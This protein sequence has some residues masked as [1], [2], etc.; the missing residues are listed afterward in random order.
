MVRDVR[1]VRALCYILLHFLVLQCHSDARLGDA[2]GDIGWFPCQYVERRGAVADR[3]SVRI[4]IGGGGGGVSPAAAADPVGDNIPAAA[5]PDSERELPLHAQLSQMSMPSAAAASAAQNGDDIEAEVAELLA[6]MRKSS[7]PVTGLNLSPP[8]TDSSRVSIVSSRPSSDSRGS[9]DR[10]LLLSVVGPACS[11]SQTGLPSPPPPVPQA[12]VEVVDVSDCGDAEGAV[13]QQAAAVAAQAASDL[14]ACDAASEVAAAAAAAAAAARPPAPRNA[15]EF[16]WMVWTGSAYE[17]FSDAAHDLIEKSLRAFEMRVVIDLST[18]QGQR[19][20]VERGSGD[21]P[22]K[23]FVNPVGRTAY[24]YDERTRKK[25]CPWGSTSH[26]I[27]ARALIHP[28][29][30]RRGS[31]PALQLVH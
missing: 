28:C 11:V 19:E 22:G 26:F 12:E 18:G 24:F 21:T 10:S 27:R 2:G 16:K 9:I 31:H 6:S 8:A 14:A 29:P 25:V 3:N 7:P 13:A 1:C 20:D 17:P 30:G 5:R 23:L 4:S 15:L